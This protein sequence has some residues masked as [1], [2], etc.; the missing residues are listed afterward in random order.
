MQYCVIVCE[1]K[2]RNDKYLIPIST[3]S[4]TRSRTHARNEPRPKYDAKITRHTRL[5]YPL[6]RFSFRLTGETF[7]GLGLRGRPVAP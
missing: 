4:G 7:P 5:I 3:K 6:Y 1:Q 2:A